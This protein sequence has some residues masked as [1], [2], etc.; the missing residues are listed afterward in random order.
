LDI[1]KALPVSLLLAALPA[2][3]QSPVSNPNNPPADRAAG[4]LIFRSHCGPC[5]GSKGTG[6]TGPNL[7]TGVFFHGG[8]DADLYRNISEGI[9][10]TA[11]PDQFFNGTQVWQ[12]VAYVRSLSENPQNTVTSGNGANGKKLVGQKGCTG[13]HL[14]RGEGGFRGPDLSVIGS[15]RS[16]E[17]LRESILDP[18]ARV[19][20]EYW[21][22]KIVMNDKSEHAGFLMNQDSY[23]VQILDFKD[24][25]ISVSRDS[26][27]DFGMDR[28]STMPPYKGK[29]TD[30]E[31]DDIVSY[32]ASL[33]RQKGSIQ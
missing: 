22:A 20:Q 7:T 17:Y 6:G 18:D 16:I 10:G 13:C 4:A 11:M 2:A 25:L 9:P 14:I 32:L 21:T 23:R 19:A 28:S 24:G 5:H 26:F 3:A 30:T 15:Q 33:Q 1:L 29:L 31:L 12:I 27:K 8:T